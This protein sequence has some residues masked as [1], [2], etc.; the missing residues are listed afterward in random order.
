ME[1]H[2]QYN[3]VKRLDLP[4]FREKC[5]ILTTNYAIMSNQI[6]LFMVAQINCA[7]NIYIS[8][9]NPTQYILQY[10]TVINCTDG[11]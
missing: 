6:I 11:T 7:A 9:S 1:Q 8:S 10:G 3:K 5:F 4:D 2:T